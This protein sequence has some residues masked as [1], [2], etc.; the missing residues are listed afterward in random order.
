[1]I[2]IIPA[3]DLIDG[4]CVRLT[5]G[6]YN[7]KKVY[8]D[9]PLEMAKM[10]E[11]KGI[12]RLH[13]VDLDG[14]RSKHV[15]NL[16]TIEEIA[17]HTSLCIDF[18]GGIKSDDDI[19]KV[20]DAGAAMVTIGS[21]AVTSPDLFINWTK[22]YGANKIIV[23]ADVK[24]GRISINGW[25]EDGNIELVPFV[26]QFLQYGVTN[27]LCTDISKD[28]T[29]N[30]PAIDLYKHVMNSLPQIN[31]IASGGVGCER[32]IEL[33]NKAGVKQVVVGKAIYEGKIDL[34][35][36]LQNV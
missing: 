6:D 34:D 7:E 3:I 26:E 36:C 15:V 9:K 17:S 27:V 1:M 5:K 10:F 12:H 32:D 24:N 33:L 11:D 16:Q 18:G 29:L 8:S 14:A 35:R 2:E 23:G 4:K 20:F 25:M 30:G 28:G 13:L 19:R 22:Q 21:V 31:L